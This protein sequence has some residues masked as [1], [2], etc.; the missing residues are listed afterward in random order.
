MSALEGKTVLVVEDSLTLLKMM[1]LR[2]RNFGARTFEA[3][4]GQQALQMVLEEEIDLVVSDVEMPVLDGLELCRRLK[5]EPSTRQIPIILLSALD[6]ETDLERGYQAGASSYISKRSND[7]ELEDTIEK[8]MEQAGRQ[9]QSLVLVV[10]DSATILKLV[11]TG[12][13]KAGF[14]VVT[15]EN[16]RAA[17]KK[18]EKYK[19]A[20]IVSDL[21]M[22]EMNGMQLRDWLRTSEEFCEVPFLVMSAN[23]EK[24]TMSQM[25]QK[26]AAG[27]L[28]KPFNIDQFVFT[29]ERLLSDQFQLLLKERERLEVERNSMLATI[30]VL[31]QALEARDPYTAGHSRRV[32]QYSLSIARQIGLAEEELHALKVGGELHD[33]GKIGISDAL[34]LKPGKLTDDEV[35]MFRHHPAIGGEILSPI[36][37]LGHMVDIVLL[38]H[39]RPDGLGYPKKLKGD[40]IPL[41]ARICAVADCF[42]ALTSDRPYRKGFDQEKAFS[43]IR[44]ISGTQLCATCVE[45]FFAAHIEVIK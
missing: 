27:Y 20:I 2:L 43:I 35:F 24:A 33:I 44:E 40:A 28:V 32:A 37:S 6:A 16:G 10:D 39:E 15:A 7:H 25:V 21:D 36:P 19:P 26:G 34:L 42:D 41:V 30:T 18:L 5:N 4:D 45:A 31:A 1:A 3:A 12:L 29:V 9:R 22:P 11:E 17:I 8:V 13:S 23:S 38:H 14:N